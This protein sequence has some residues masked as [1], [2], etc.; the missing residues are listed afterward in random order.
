MIKPKSLRSTCKLFIPDSTGSKLCIHYIPPYQVGECGFC[1][2]PTIFRC[3]EELKQKQPS[4]SHSAVQT[5]TAC[6][7]AYYYYYV[8][9]IRIKAEHLPKVMKMGS[10]WDKF[11]EVQHFGNMDDV[12][13]LKQKYNLE[14]LESAKLS[15]LMDAYK[16]LEIGSNITL[17]QP[18]LEVQSNISGNTVVG[19]VDV[20]H[21]N[22][23]EE[24]KLTTRP[25]KYLAVE[26]IFNQ[27]GTYFLAVQDWEYVQMMIVRT[28][29]L[30]LRKEESIDSYY[31]RTY[32]DII[33]RPGYYFQGYDNTTRTYGNTTKFYRDEFDL[34]HLKSKY[35]YIFQEI[36]DTLNRGSWYQEEQF[37][38]DPYPCPYYDIKKTGVVSENIYYYST[39]KKER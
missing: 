11:I 32:D 3:H 27:V 15:A 10:I 8:L 12:I 33:S 38:L 26:S 23:F 35:G 34:E 5:W 31:K 16:D 6:K 7:M 36:R 2:C 39:G 19:F 1:D 24:H 29:G 4:L 22:Y 28:P 14:E 37:C 21:D 9:G 18:Q 17:G 20:A 25:E 13:D 30:Y